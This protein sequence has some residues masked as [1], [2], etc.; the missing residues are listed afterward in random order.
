M[1]Y[2]KWMY[3]RILFY[4]AR[5]ITEQIGK[6]EDYEQIKPVIS[7]IIADHSLLSGDS[8]Y[9]HCFRLYDAQ[10]KKEF[11]HRLMEIHTLEIPKLPSRGGSSRLWSWLRFFAAKT[12]GDFE[13]VAKKDAV[14]SE[15]YHALQEL[16]SDE[17]TRWLAESREKARRDEYARNAYRNDL[18]EKRGLKKGRK[19][20]GREKA[21]TIARAALKKGIAVEVIAEIS[22]LSLKEV[23]ALRKSEG[24]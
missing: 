6:G 4:A 9:H 12:E 5:M 13:M 14:L 1:D 24:E 2:Q 20:G 7:I 15:T 18:A 16:S 10:V 22:G 3:E 8:P 21:L 23:L 19:E 11:P 17:Y